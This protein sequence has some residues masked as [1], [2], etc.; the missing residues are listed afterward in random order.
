MFHLCILSQ[1]CV[2]QHPLQARAENLAQASLGQ[3]HVKGRTRPRHAKELVQQDLRPHQ[4]HPLHNSQMD[5]GKL[6]AV[7]ASQVSNRNTMPTLWEEQSSPS[8]CIKKGAA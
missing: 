5:F 1:A 2:L 3:Q 7:V 6:L 8:L 4:P